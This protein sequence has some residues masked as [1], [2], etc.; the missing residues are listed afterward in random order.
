MEKLDFLSEPPAMY[1][2]QKN[3][4]KTICGG[5]LTLIMFVIMGLIS[6]NYIYDYVISDTYSFEAFRMSNFTTSQE[7]MRKILTEDKY[8]TNLTF[9]ILISND[10]FIVYK[11]I[12]N[13]YSF[14][15]KS[16]IDI[17]NFSHYVFNETSNGAT[18][19]IVY[20]C[21]KDINCTS[22]YDLIKANQIDFGLIKVKYPRK[23]INH[24]ADIPITED[25]EEKLDRIG[26]GFTPDLDYFTSSFEWEIIIYEDQVSFFESFMGKNKEYIFGHFKNEK[27]ER[28]KYNLNINKLRTMK[29]GDDYFLI[30]SKSFFRFNRN[31]EY[32][33]YRRKKIS[34][35]D[36]IGNISALFSPINM[37]F[38][39]IF[40][41]YSGNFDN[42][43][44]LEN[45][46]KPKKRQKPIKPK[47]LQN[48]IHKIEKIDIDGEGGLAF[49]RKSKTVALINKS[50]KSKDTENKK[51]PDNPS[52]PPSP[53]PPPI[54]LPKICCCTYV[55]NNC[56][57]EC[58]CKIDIQ[59]KINLM[60]DIIQKYMSYDSLLYNQILLENLFLDY[61]W[62][63]ERLSYIQS[64]EAI[65]ELNPI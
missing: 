65:S 48:I 17:F 10:D 32:L 5:I 62:N 27:P 28:E 25:N 9:D 54:T 21:G 33:L 3:T 24:T 6:A 19:D 42:Y 60:G 56:Y 16:Y 40:S 31:F 30:V 11:G 47:E 50:D 53:P 26:I 37:I 20:K 29:D 23:L 22:F 46:L 45:I 38:S 64:N 34:F 2:F 1:I 51:P 59:N 52:A 35:L 61:K 18:I 57:S 49:E 36:V 14:P 63:N 58:C 4:N 44:I 39:F 55:L 13:N 41:L 8:I 15:E 7:D 43:S 12:G